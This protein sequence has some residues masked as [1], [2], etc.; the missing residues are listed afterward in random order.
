MNKQ[1]RRV[2]IAAQQTFPLPRIGRTL[3]T[4]RQVREQCQMNHVQLA[5]LAGV[6]SFIAFCMEGG[7]SVSV[8]D[9][10]AVLATLSLL[11]RQVYG[12]GNVRGIRLKEGKR[13]RVKV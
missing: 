12:F 9:A 2:M 13:A 3:P 8:A 6:R 7:I 4:L 11:T 10:E 1:S 5:R